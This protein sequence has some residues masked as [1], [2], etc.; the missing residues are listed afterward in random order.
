M[1]ER[2]TRL[3]ITLPVSVATELRL[4]HRRTGKPLGRLLLDRLR[5]GERAARRAEK[6]EALW[7]ETGLALVAAQRKANAR[8]TAERRAE[9]AR[10]AELKARLTDEVLELSGQREELLAD[11]EA[12]ALERAA[13]KIVP[14]VFRA[15]LGDPV[16]QREAT[17]LR[18]WYAT[19]RREEVS[20]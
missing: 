17:R 4:E 3:H 12:E 11:I 2:M 1:A 18:D 5:E 7:R 19:M 20:R 6:F 9:L 10:L 14:L 15:D 16:A 8:D 13:A